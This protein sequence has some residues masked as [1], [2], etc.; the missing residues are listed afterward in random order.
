MYRGGA[1]HLNEAP[2]HGV[3]FDERE[4]AKHPPHDRPTVWTEMRLPDGTLHTP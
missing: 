3:D 4:A 1:I 2:G